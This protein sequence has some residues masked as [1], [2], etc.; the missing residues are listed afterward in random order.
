MTKI[1]VY[2]E[3]TISNTQATFFPGEGHFFI[4]KRWGEIL[5]QMVD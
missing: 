3:D 1:V 4:L 2:V 5:E